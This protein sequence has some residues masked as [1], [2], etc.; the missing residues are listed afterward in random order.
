MKIIYNILYSIFIVISK[1]DLIFKGLYIKYFSNNEENFQ[2]FSLIN[3]FQCKNQWMKITYNLLEW[4]LKKILKIRDYVILNVSYLLKIFIKVKR[5]IYFVLLK[6]HYCVI[7]RMNEKSYLT[8]IKKDRDL[9]KDW[10]I[11]GCKSN[12]CSTFL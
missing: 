2:L 4:I 10:K 3:L 6:M 7:M 12:L 1:K 5:Y 9:K 8:I 11:S